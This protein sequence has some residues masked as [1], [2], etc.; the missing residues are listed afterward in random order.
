MKRSFEAVDIM[1]AVGFCAT[2]LGGLL[3]SLASNGVMGPIIGKAVSTTNIMPELDLVEPALGEAIVAGTLLERSA[4]RETAAAAADLNRAT[5]LSYEFDGSEDG[6]LGQT[7]AWA[8]NMTSASAARAEL[9]RGRTI[10]NGTQRGIARGLLSADQY[11][12]AYNDRIIQQ[13]DAAGYRVTDMFES[14]HQANLGEAVVGATLMHMRSADQI[15]EGIGAAVVRV[16]RARF[17]YDEANGALQEQTAALFNAA[18]RA[19]LQADQF[20]LLAEAPTTAEPIAATAAPRSWPE[21]STGH[22]L[23]AAAALLGVLM[24]GLFM[25]ASRRL[26]EELKPYAGFE[27]AEPVYRKTA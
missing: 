8:D 2:I 3:L 27:Q 1:V 14:T 13:A 22:V 19:D 5:M 20:T 11:V 21:I 17:G 4:D 15:Q 6:V 24:A 25:A 12:N 18:V 23:G 10:V 26:P 7:K 9:V 16:A